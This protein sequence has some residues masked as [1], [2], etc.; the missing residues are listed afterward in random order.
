MIT[1]IRLENFRCF[2][3]HVVPFRPLTIIVGQNNAG[4]SSLVDALRLLALVTT[5]FGRLHFSAI[6]RWLDIPKAHRG[7]S[8][9][10]EGIDVTFDIVFHRYN[11]PP[12]IITATFHSGDSIRLYLGPD[13]A[14]FAVL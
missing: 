6:P 14:L 3:D 8:P 11:D 7:I 5:R 9:S 1:K 2:A 4:K 10:V 13:G 12:A